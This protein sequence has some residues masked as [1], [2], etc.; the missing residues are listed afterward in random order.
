MS[1]QTYRKWGWRWLVKQASH[2]SPV[3]HGRHAW[4]GGRAMVFLLPRVK[5]TKVSQRPVW[6]LPSLLNTLLSQ[7]ERL[8]LLICR[9][10]LNVASHTPGSNNLVLSTHSYRDNSASCYIAT[11]PTGSIVITGHL[12]HAA[13][14]QWP[15]RVHYHPLK[16]A[17]RQSLPCVPKAS[18]REGEPFQALWD[19]TDWEKWDRVN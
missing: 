19:L 12:T 6:V 16:A 5:W 2:V 4:V 18:H 1:S 11:L 10:Q 13:L 8:D 9:S 15:S 3:L 17:E 14:P 7:S